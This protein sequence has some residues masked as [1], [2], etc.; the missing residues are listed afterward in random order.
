MAILP[1]V[2]Q[3]ALFNS[4]NQS[5]S[6]FA[7]EHS[8]VHTA[9]VGLFTCPGDPL[10]GVAR[11]HA[12]DQS[13]LGWRDGRL[14]V[15]GSYVGSYG[16]L[17]VNTLPNPRGTDCTVDP[18]LL[19]QANGSITGV[20]PIG[21][22]AVVDGLSTTMMISERAVTLVRDDSEL[23][24]ATYGDWYSGRPGD[25]LFSAM[26]PPNFKPRDVTAGMASSLHG[27]GVHVGL[28][29][30]SA[31]FVKETIDSWP[32]DDEYRPLGAHTL[33]HGGRG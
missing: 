4:I 22:S 29:D 1:Q 9:S 6:I 7:P 12:P 10:S 2:E 30:G 8:T 27:G 23:T 32:L 14:S 17:F 26:F 13:P 19:S 33:P 5:L 11:A 15:T 3:A 24:Y 20:A 31:R 18:R 25:S 28:C 16:S 21:A